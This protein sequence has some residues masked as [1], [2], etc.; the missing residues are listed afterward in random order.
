M[1]GTAAD[2]VLDPEV[3]DVGDLHPT[4]DEFGQRRDG[5]QPA[6]GHLQAVAARVEEARIGVGDRDDDAGDVEPVDHLGDVVARAPH[7]HPVDAQVPFAR[8]VV[9]EPTGRYAPCGSESICRM[10]DSAASPAPTTSTLSPC[11]GRV[12][13]WCTQRMT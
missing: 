7:P 2:E 8:I 11:R 9:D 13:N 6:A 12:A 3:A 4:V 1:D 5:A 10:R